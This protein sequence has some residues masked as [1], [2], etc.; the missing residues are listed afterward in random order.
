MAGSTGALA[1]FTLMNAGA[2]LWVAGLA[3]DL[4]GGTEL[5]REAIGSG[6]AKALL[7]RYV[8]LSQELAS[9]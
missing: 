2:S 8:A 1:D 9:G 4:K 6:R 3:D 5:A 7:E